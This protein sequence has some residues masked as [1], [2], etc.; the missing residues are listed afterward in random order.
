M[1]K[2]IVSGHGEFAS[3]I[4]KTLE[5][6]I[7]KQENIDYINFNNGMGI[8]E[9]EERYIESVLKNEDRETLFLTDLAG[10]TPFSTAVTLSQS[11]KDIYVLGG[12]NIPTILAAIEYRDQ[13]SLEKTVGDIINH[14]K[15]SIVTFQKKELNDNF[16][17]DDGI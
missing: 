11:M 9:L 4:E 12:I 15:E 2:I 16:Q 7:G 10:G 8:K 3:A 1:F 13:E 14:G 17:N 6:I 5:Y